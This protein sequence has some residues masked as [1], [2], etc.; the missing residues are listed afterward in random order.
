MKQNET[1]LN[2][3]DRDIHIDEIGDNHIG[4]TLSS[5]IRSDAFEIADDLKI[6]LIEQHFAEIMNILGLD[7]ND[8]SLNGTPRRVAKM[9]V[10]EIFSGL[11]PKNKPK[12]TLFE[13]KYD[14]KEMLVEKDITLFSC[15][16][17]HFQPFYGK[18]HVAYK[19]TGQVIGLSKLNRIVQYYAQ[20]PQLQERLTK[21][22]ADE[23]KSV[24]KTEHVAVV[25]EA[26]HMCVST[27]GV[28]DHGSST[29]TADYHGDFL[30]N[31]QTRNE[32][33]GYIGKK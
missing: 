8:D 31:S 7:L 30:S 2:T 25:I 18:A 16:E 15:C 12:M 26:H 28:K 32:F 11:N 5:P 3:T 23:L 22:I 10:K 19:S 21:Q 29:V 27:R 9:Y 33:L 17:H 14:Y 24:L 20:R 1:L 6:G 4:N 13:N